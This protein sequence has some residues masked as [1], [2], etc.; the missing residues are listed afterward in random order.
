MIFGLRSTSRGKIPKAGLSLRTKLPSESVWCQHFIG[1]IAGH[2][3]LSQIH[4]SL[5]PKAVIYAV[6][7]VYHGL[8]S[9]NMSPWGKDSRVY[10]DMLVARHVYRGQRPHEVI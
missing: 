5:G 8:L 6:Q 10:I 1:S 2:A 4:G 7:G 9:V 3:R